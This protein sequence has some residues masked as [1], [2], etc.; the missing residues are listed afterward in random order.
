MK[1]DGEIADPRAVAAWKAS[2]ASAPPKRILDFVGLTPS[3][4]TGFRPGKIPHKVAVDRVQTLLEH[5]GEMPVS[6]R[7]LLSGIGL[8]RSLL[9]VLSE[10]AIGAA[11]NDMRILFSSDSLYSAMLLSDRE[12][13]RSMGIAGLAQGDF[14]QPDA[15][16]RESAGAALNELFRPLVEVLASSMKPDS[17]AL[18]ASAGIGHG[19]DVDAEKKYSRIK[20]ELDEKSREAKRLGRELAK[21]KEDLEKTLTLNK[22][23]ASSLETMRAVLA[24]EKTEHQSL[25]RSF[26]QAVADETQRRVDARVLPWLEQAEGLASA[27]AQSGSNDIL[28]QAEALLS[29]QEQADRRYG[30]WSR[31]ARERDDCLAMIER[32][33]VAKTE[34]VQPLPELGPAT[35]LLVARVAELERTLGAGV[36][37]ST[38]RFASQEVFLRLKEAATLEELAALRADL[39]ASSRIGLLDAKDLSNAY[40]LI[41]ETCWKLYSTEPADEA[42]KKDAGWQEM[43]PLHVLQRSL[44]QGDS[45]LLLIDGHNVLF[46]LRVILQL[47]FEGNSPGPRARRQLVDNL[48]PLSAV[49]RNLDTH[50]WYDGENAHDISVSENLVVHYSGGEGSNRADAQIVK[51]L[52]SMRYMSAGQQS[53]RKALVTADRELSEQARSHGALILAPEE[54]AILVSQPSRD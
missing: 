37:A 40:R 23:L 8:D 9:A 49:F 3:L 12:G 34:S 6:L 29:R 20:S 54:L 32:L 45:C 43:L 28:H 51:Y 31:L 41:E 16:E 52:H 5:T 50:L 33:N 44:R 38:T 36:I 35:A 7:N 25:A 46:K 10:E 14:T 21:T 1:I 26:E 2:V 47:E 22:G 39:E 13:V 42:G 15:E 53:R 11:R 48:G 19:L 27:V 4:Q 18:P 17:V 24:T 30:L